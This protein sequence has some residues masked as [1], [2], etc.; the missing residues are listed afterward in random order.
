MELETLGLIR[1]RRAFRLLAR[2]R[3]DSRRIQAGPY[4]AA[5]DEWAWEILGRLVRG[6]TRD[7]TV[8]VREGLWLTEVGE[9]VGPLVAGGADSFLTLAREEA[10]VASLGLSSPTLEGFLFPD[11]YRVI[12]GM[13]PGDLIRLMVGTFQERWEGQLSAAAA[14]RNLNQL[15][16]VTLA[17]I[18]EAEAQVAAERPRIAAV[19]LNRLSRGMVLQADP[20]VAYALGERRGRILYDDLE[21][22]SPYNTYRFPGL[23]PGPIGNPGLESLRAVLWPQPDCDDLFFVARGDGTHL[24]GRTFEEHRQNRR[25]VE[26]ERTRAGRSLGGG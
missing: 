12:P 25:Q 23:P 10:F 13:A 8:T 24:F 1:D 16:V 9:A 19:Y 22:D 5:S 18:V 6:D 14:A 21:S 2:I 17:S 7:T 4:Q 26:R 20:T 3:G 15:E 11:T